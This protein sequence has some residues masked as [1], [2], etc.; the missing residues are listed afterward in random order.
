MSSVVYTSQKMVPVID[1]GGCISVVI[2]RAVVYEVRDNITHAGTDVVN[3][4]SIKVRPA[5][6]STY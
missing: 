6:F 1:L 2:A 5:F 4:G 3:N